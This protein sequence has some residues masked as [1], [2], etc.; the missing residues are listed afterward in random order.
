MVNLAPVSGALTFLR[1]RFLLLEEADFMYLL[2]GLLIGLAVAVPIGPVGLMCLENTVS[3]GKKAGLSCASGM[4]LA[5]IFSASVMLVGIGL[6]YESIL[7]YE[8]VFKVVTGLIF[9]A[10][11]AAILMQR[12]QVPKYT[13]NTALAGLSVSSFVLAVSP[14][15]F[16]LMLFL[17]PALGLTEHAHPVPVVL[18]VAI[19]SAAWCSLILG[20]GKFIRS[21]LG[22]RLPMFKLVVGIIFILFGIVGMIASVLG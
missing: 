3:C 9:S 4:V 10:M 19:G 1:C 12:N 13:S 5:D 17:F 15:T 6:F 2:K 20:A 22:N 7:A 11:G 8:I 21:C 14:A 18:G 16:A